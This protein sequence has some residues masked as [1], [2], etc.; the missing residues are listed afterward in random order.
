M[1]GKRLSRMLRSMLNE[2]SGSNYLDS[3]TTYDLLNQASGQLNNKLEQL[4]TTVELTTV[5]NQ[6][7]YTLPANYMRLTRV[8]EEGRKIVSCR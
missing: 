5:A 6:A 3:F 8:N 4:E 7:D 2:E 1:D